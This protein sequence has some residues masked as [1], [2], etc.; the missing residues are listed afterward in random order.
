[1]AEYTAYLERDE[2]IAQGI[3][4]NY[5]SARC[6]TSTDSEDD[7]E[8]QEAEIDKKF[9]Y[10]KS[11]TSQVLRFDNS[12]TAEL[13]HPYLG[14]YG[15]TYKFPPFAITHS[16]YAIPADE[17]PTLPQGVRLISYTPDYEDVSGWYE[18]LTGP[19]PGYFYYKTDP[20]LKVWKYRWITRKK[21]IGV[22]SITLTKDSTEVKTSHP[23]TGVIKVRY[24]Y[25][26]APALRRKLKDN[27]IVEAN[28]NFYLNPVGFDA[29]SKE[30]DAF[31]L[32]SEEGDY[33]AGPGRELWNELDC[34]ICNPITGANADTTPPGGYEDSGSLVSLINSARI[35]HPTECTYD[36]K[37][38]CVS[39]SLVLLAEDYANLLKTKIEEAPNITIEN[40]LWNP[41]NYAFIVDLFGNPYSSGTYTSP[42]TPT[43]R[44]KEYIY[45]PELWYSDEAIYFE[46]FD[47][48]IDP[49]EDAVREIAFAHFMET[50]KGLILNGNYDRGGSAIVKFS[51]WEIDRGKWVYK[52]VYVVV[53]EMYGP[54]QQVVRDCEIDY[55]TMPSPSFTCQPKCISKPCEWYQQIYGDETRGSNYYYLSPDIVMPCYVPW[56][57]SLREVLFYTELG[58]YK[59]GIAPQW[60]VSRGFGDVQHENPYIDLNEVNATIIWQMSD[61]IPFM[62]P[63]E[64]FYFI[65][66]IA[67][68]EDAPC[69]FLYGPSGYFE[70]HCLTSGTILGCGY[71]D[72]SQGGLGVAYDKNNSWVF[73]ENFRWLVSYK[74]NSFWLRPSDFAK[75]DIGDRVF[76][77]KDGEM[78]LQSK[79]IACKGKGLFT[80]WDEVQGVQ[81]TSKN[82]T[83]SLDSE[84]D[85]V[86]PE[87][88]ADRIG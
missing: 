64:Y 24:Y 45:D 30:I 77:Y 78:Q 48:G 23:W 19:K 14:S 7:R 71:A 22:P 58:G 54:Q 61:V 43:G 8:S 82:V 88:L 83:Y 2:W 66:I 34:L 47:F 39:E 62:I 31:I 40:N 25:D 53:L 4:S 86:I 15:S 12:D 56:I 44:M 17:R 65:F 85:L 1:M 37:E 3:S 18:Y 76:I 74:G 10:A 84:K 33:W 11:Q 16:T 57:C 55:S 38:V 5:T 50:K 73:N 6:K 20:P 26:R 75:Y 28:Y 69:Q 36:C 42:N 46:K 87:S 80:S 63:G 51:L 79:S 29:A 52:W 13:N 67:F 59:A 21:E 9:I 68:G 49:G 60:G 41:H 35:T 27:L 32:P 70:T 72:G 81:L